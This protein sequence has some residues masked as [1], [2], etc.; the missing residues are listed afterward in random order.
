MRNLKFAAIKWLVP[1]GD[2][3]NKLLSLIILISFLLQPT[4]YFLH[5]AAAYAQET[6]T[7]SAR[8]IE[9]DDIVHKNDDQEF[10][11]L[12]NDLFIDSSLASLTNTN[13]SAASINKKLRK[14]I[15]ALLKKTF[16]STEKIPVII[17][18][19]DPSQVK[20]DVFDP[21]GNKVNVALDA[22]TI[23]DAAV[24]RVAP[25][26]HFR[27]GKYK[28]VIT[29]S[30]GA[31]STQDFTWGVLAINTNKSVYLP[32]ETAKLSIAV[33]DET[34]NMVCDAKV[35]LDIKDPQGNTMSHSTDESTIRVNP[36]CT[37]KVFSMEPDFEARYTVGGPGTYQM[38]LTSTTKN[39]TYTITDA[40][41]VAESVPFDVERTS[42]TRIFPPLRYPV[43]FGIT[44]NE[45]FEGEISEVVP[46]TFDVAPIEGMLPFDGVATHSA[47][48]I[49]PVE[50]VAI[51]HP[52]SGSYAKTQGFGVDE[53]DD[54]MSAKYKKY[55]LLGHDGIDFALPKGTPV[56]SVD[57]GVIAKATD[58]GDYGT[59][60]IVQHSWGRSYYG[61]LSE[62][63]VKVGDTVSKGQEIGLSGNT[64][65][66]TTGPHL[67]FGIKFNENNPSNGYYG[68]VNPQPYFTASQPQSVLG[69]A[70]G[71][72]VLRN[73]DAQGIQIITW[74][75][76]V[77]KGDKIDLG[78]TYLSPPKSP[79]F[80]TLGPLAFTKKGEEDFPEFVEARRWQ[81]AVD[82]DGSG[83]MTINETNG[84]TSE[85]Y[86]S[87]T[88]TYTTGETVATGSGAITIQE[89]SADDWTT[90]QTSNSN[91]AGYLSVDTSASTGVVGDVLDN[92]DSNTNWSFA[93][94][95]GANHL[96]C[97]S[98]AQAP[99]VTTSNFPEGSGALSC[100]NQGVSSGDGFY[101]SISSSDWSNYTTVGVWLKTSAAVSTAGHIRFSYDDT[102]ALA[103]PIADIARSSGSVANIW[104]WETFTLSGTRTSIVSYGITYGSNTTLDSVTVTADYF[105]IGP[106]TPTVSGTSPW[107]ITVP[108]VTIPANTGT[109]VLKYGTNTAGGGVTNSS[110]ATTHTFTTRSK[111]ATN[112]V[113]TLTAI[114]TSPTITLVT[115]PTGAT[116]NRIMRNGKWFKIGTEQPFI[117]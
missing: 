107:T 32:N 109:I 103:S 6:A 55:G 72:A 84:V 56:L 29:D 98:P 40:F 44:A 21:D 117:F 83:T 54:A 104:K 14:N 115:T 94:G 58:N 76:N 48:P 88:F 62:M 105:L 110:S 15:R 23:V 97:G 36:Q 11:K 90:P 85:G 65:L 19:E 43:I 25:P 111:I 50:S 92:G 86:K 26:P 8:N 87:Y 57:N 53:T 30:T 13:Q 81:I 73:D 93:G 100:A 28:M 3:I 39:G 12:K 63:K 1:S 16:K 33:L 59:T 4:T 60:I 101:K 89:P 35:K 41:E 52:F 34:G 20:I 47:E 114:S 69:V 91:N 102:A 78:Y 64:G 18:N 9:I 74:K 75:V 2:K 95:G 49:T 67:H 71:S 24:V 116:N 7:S 80:Y 17:D 108:I 42:V 113:N 10:Q 112:R 79:Q 99:S 106:G 22:T 66:L 38:T 68:K 46:E 51:S 61:H 5:P 82:A 96:V 31:T 27:P 70:T 77:K 37:L 45:D